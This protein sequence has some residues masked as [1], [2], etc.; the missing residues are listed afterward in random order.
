MK[1]A[2][3]ALLLISSALAVDWT[4]YTCAQMGT[5]TQSSFTCSVWGTF[6]PAQV[7]CLTQLTACGILSSC[8]SSLNTALY[9]A[10]VAQCGNGIG[11]QLSSTSTGSPN[12]RP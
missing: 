8:P 2:F 1:Y 3:V 9:A 7:P 12:V 10:L 4:S 11:S 6:P 5:F